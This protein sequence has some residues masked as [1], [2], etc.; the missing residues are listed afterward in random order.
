M[1]GWQETI[2]C[3][4]CA[5]KQHVLCLEISDDELNFFKDSGFECQACMSKKSLIVNDNTP[6]RPLPAGQ[7]VTN[8][9]FNSDT[10]INDNDLVVTKANNLIVSML[11]EL[12]NTFTNKFLRMEKENASLFANLSSEV[13][14]LKEELITLNEE[15]SRLRSILLKK[16]EISN[17]TSCTKSVERTECNRVI[18]ANKVTVATLKTVELEIEG[19]VQQANEIAVGVKSKETWAE[20]AGKPKRINRGVHTTDN[21]RTASNI[22][23]V[24]KKKL[25]SVEQKKNRSRVQVGLWKNTNIAITS[26]NSAVC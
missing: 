18:S 13:A 20:V 11:R 21:N 16:L 4:I 23:S 17:V 5:L 22:T 6:V 19:A 8:Q 9:S 7:A 14:A 2:Q 3:E 24:F 1:Y 10:N 15:N 26:R 25:D 12:E